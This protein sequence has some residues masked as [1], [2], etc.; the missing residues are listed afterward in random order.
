MGRKEMNA[1]VGMLWLG[2][3]KQSGFEFTAFCLSSVKGLTGLLL[4]IFFPKKGGC[5]TK[6]GSI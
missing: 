1:V 4:Q 2:K 6:D 3:R 5:I